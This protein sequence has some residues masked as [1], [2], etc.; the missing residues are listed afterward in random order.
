MR[1]SEILDALPDT[2]EWMVLFNLSAVRK[3]ANDTTTRA[4]Y[5][6]PSEIELEPY[7]HVVLTSYGRS[8]ATHHGSELI[9]PLSGQ[10]WSRQQSTPSLG[11]RFAAQLALF[12]VD[13][14]DCLGLGEQSP[15]SP[16]LLHVKIQSGYGQAQAIFEQ[17]PSK[18]HYELLRAVGVT[19][20]GGECKGDYYLAR[21]QN[22][23]PTHIHAGILSHFS[24]TAHC[25]LFFLQQGQIDA[26]LE[27]GLLKAAAD[28]IHRAS[29][30]GLKALAKLTQAACLHTPMAMTCQPPPPSQPFPYGDLVPLGFV[31]K[32]LNRAVINSSAGTRESDSSATVLDAHKTLSQ[33]LLSKRQGYLW[34]FH[35]SR[36]I[37]S[38]DSALI[39]QGF[40][41]PEAVAALELF[42]DGQGG[43][44][45]QLWSDNQQPG[46]M[47]FDESYRHWCQS[48]YATTCL[49]RALQQEAE[50]ET[51]TPLDYLAA[52]FETRSGLYFAN[53]YLVDWALAQAIR[54]DESAAPLRQK[55]LAEI[56]AS[57][58]Q[59]YS[60]GCYD[61]AL[62]TALAILS[63]A[64]LGFRGRTLRMA[65][66][67]LLEFMDTR[68]HWPVAIPFYSSVHLDRDVHFDLEKQTSNHQIGQVQGQTHAISLYID[69][70]QMIATALA[71]LALSE[72][73]LPENPDQNFHDRQQGIHPRYQCLNPIEYITTV[74]LPPYLVN[75][76]LT[77]G[78]VLL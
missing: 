45:P 27:T 67:R 76:Q 24:R 12:S 70:H 21:F 58:N 61:V 25:N 74:A 5:H 22:H 56:L 60:F 51:K 59:D 72:P 64:A 78:S 18:E 50:I 7:S 23:L 1:V 17:E 30:R 71:V 36:L 68:G 48:D 6:L 14:A 52:R 65:Q 3:L 44:Y 69:T 77:A 38:T 32:A 34:A 35:T 41:H 43:Y 16:V 49:V 39:L 40:N 9:E 46:K 28:R 10:R 42:A 62:S 75:R 66:L 13:D 31:L 4:M 19:F 15:F 53:P 11:D 8:L 2:L 57:M 33:F 29:D 73:C 37:T 47:R 20:L 63:M 26:A 54:S 55:L